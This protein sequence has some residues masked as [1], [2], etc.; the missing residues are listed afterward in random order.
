MRALLSFAALF[1]SIFL[2]QM[3][4]GVLGPLDVLAG[5]AR[6]FTDEE[7]GVLGSAHFAG[8]F[9]GCWLAP[10]YV[11]LIGHSRSFA[12]AAAIGATGALLHPVL[13]GP[14]W[15]AGLRVLTGIAIA[16]A[17]TV[18]ESWLQG[19]TQ[20]HNRGRVYGAFRVVDMGGQI[21]AQAMIAV[22]DPASYA[23]YNIV[24]VFC[25]LCLLPLALSRRT[26]PDLPGA[27]RLRP[28]RTYMLSPLAAIGIIVAGLAG[29]SFRM[30][31][32]LFGLEN[33]LSQGQ[34]A[35]FLSAS[36]IGGI[37]VQYPVGWVADKFD[38]RT[39]LVFL[40]LAAIGCCIWT[41]LSSSSP[42]M[43]YAAAAL[44]GATSYPVF[45]VSS[46]LANDRATPDMMLEVNASLI[47]YYSVGALIS[48]TVSAYLINE[49][50]S[51]ALFYFIA[52]AHLALVLF[53][54]YRMTRR[55]TAE[56]VAPY[57]YTPRTSM[58]L[59]RMFGRSPDPDSPAT[60]GET[61]RPA[62][63]GDDERTAR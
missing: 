30:V 10:R 53:A 28:I 13:E 25:C 61:P 11:G 49:Y 27:P 57:S 59:A 63:G 2:V 12:A 16:S 5:K 22:L 42:I 26:A 8:F 1:L 14:L 44:F 18:T 37:L 52:G 20:N 50:G 34:I 24:A 19:K 3:G 6:G 38:R 54:L 7:I 47:F 62:D 33:G 4:S 43:L 29:A 36:M 51:D 17:Y 40:S 41:T 15:W 32:P 21:T 39:V 45:S 23:A 35:L 9:I 56:P 46:A 31:G 55:E 60:L 58:V 48:P